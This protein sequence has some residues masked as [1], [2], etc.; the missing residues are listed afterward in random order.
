[1]LSTDAATV[2]PADADTRTGALTYLDRGWSVIPIRPRDKRPLLPWEEFQN[3]RAT[4]DE[5]DEW[6]KRWPEMN[7]AV[8]TGAISGVTVVDVDGDVGKSSIGRQA[9]KVPTTQVQR[10]PHGWHMFFKHRAG[11]GNKVGLLPHVDVRNDGGYVLVSPSRLEDGGYS[12]YKATDLQPFP[13]WLIPAN[14]AAPSA[15]R[16]GSGATTSAPRWVSRALVEGAPMHHRNDMAAK[17]AGYFYSRSMPMDV[18]AAI[19]EPFRAACQPP[20]DERELDTVLLS[21]A[22]YHDT[23]RDFGIDNPPTLSKTLTGERYTWEDL[24]VSVEFGALAATKFGGGYETEMIVECQIPNYPKR[25]HGPVRYNLLSTQSRQ[26]VVAYMQRRLPDVNWAEIFETASR[27]VIESFRTGSTVM[28]LVDA[29][30]PPGGRYA[31]PP[32]LVNDAATCIF[33]D[34]GVGKSLFALAATCALAGDDAV[35]AGMASPVQHRVAYLDWEWDAWQHRERMMQLCGDRAYDLA[36]RVFYRRCQGPLADMVD[37]LKRMIDEHGIT[38]VVI[39]SVGAACAGEPEAAKNAMAFYDATRSLGCGSLWLAHIAKDGSTWK[40]FG[41]VF[42]HNN[43]RATWYLEKKQDTGQDCYTVGAYQRKSNIGKLEKP[44]AFEVGF[45][46]DRIH[47]LSQDIGTIPE[48]SR[49]LPLKDQIAGV[50]ATGQRTVDEIAE[51]LEQP[52][53]T[54]RVRLSE[55]KRNGRVTTFGTR[56]GTYGLTEVRHTSNFTEDW[57]DK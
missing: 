31:L 26:Q 8:V 38:Y 29:P 47:I 39:D 51:L 48:L 33:A 20:M 55:M 32:M 1:M 5:V 36:D 41:S 18:V 9:G 14:A 53:E 3:R 43:A 49:G 13:E 7:L 57:G 21:V 2:L 44:M 24:N 40:P 54:I 15:S 34:G 42:W 17:L 30:P 19:M 52:R 23:A 11:I 10:T 45:V 16:N 37:S 25:L 4:L 35:F 46:A 27:L 56:S 50:L 6:V 22:R 28:R 12:W